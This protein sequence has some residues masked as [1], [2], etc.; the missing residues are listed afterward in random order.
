MLDTLSESTTPLSFFTFLIAA[1]VALF[2]GSLLI[3]QLKHPHAFGTKARPDLFAPPGTYPFL[4]LWIR[5]LL[6][7]DRQPELWVRFLYEREAAGI[8]DPSKAVSSTIPFRRFVGMT[9][10]EHLQHIQLNNFSNYAKGPISRQVMGQVLGRG[11]FTSDGEA[12]NSQ[13]K[14][15]SRIFTNA[16]YRDIISSSIS[17]SLYDFLSVMAYFADSGK[18]IKLSKLFFSVT[19]DSFC[20]MAFST[21]PGA[22]K[23]EKEGKSVPFAAA[24]DYTQL[25]MTRRFSNP[26]FKLTEFLTGERGRM[27]SAV[28][29]VHS[30]TNNLIREREKEL[31]AKREKGDLDGEQDGEEGGGGATDLLGQFL[32]MRE[33]EGLSDEAVRDATINLIIAGRDTTA[34]NLSWCCFHLLKQPHLIEKLRAEAVE[35]GLT[36]LSSSS[37]AEGERVRML[38]FDELKEMNYSLAVWYETA[39]LHPAVPVNFWQALGD[40]QIPNGPRIEKGDLVAWSDW[41][42]ARN[43]SLWGSDAGVFNPSRWLDG[44][45]G[46]FRKES[47][48]LMHSFNGGRRRC[49]GEVLANFEGVA[50]LLALLLSF[51]LDFAPN[52]LDKTEMVRTEWCGVETPRYANALTL[53]ML[54]PLR[55]VA[56]RRKTLD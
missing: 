37:D 12:W 5:E 48:F 4:G 13:R 33:K 43:V 28:T 9:T 35:H 47:E 41:A 53:P 14:A 19:L 39:R 15:T 56:T 42:S 52:Y 31:E 45:T 55:V 11:I 36:G 24:F 22:V 49:L 23:G 40:D 21:S 6:V 29:V 3:D 17:S 32:R 46:K 27:K 8:K 44:K 50:I 16:N 38:E 25:V 51:D 10:P 2:L 18:E 34:G 7:R 20:E 54:K 26:L 30:Y 1:V